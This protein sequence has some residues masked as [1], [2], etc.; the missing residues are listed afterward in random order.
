[1]VTIAIEMPVFAGNDEDELERFFELYKGYIHNI[2]INPSAIASNLAGWE[3]AMGILYACLTDP[4]TRWY[5]TNILGK[6]D[7]LKNIL[8][9]AIHGDEPAFKALASNASNYPPNTWV[10][11]SGAKLI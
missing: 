1:M 11:P 2:G 5:N 8:L 7:R 6:K 9:H 10:D 4:A 3:K